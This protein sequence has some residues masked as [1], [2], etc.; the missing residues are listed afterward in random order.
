MS[1]PCIIPLPGALGFTHVLMYGHFCI[2]FLLD[3]LSSSE[4]N[5]FKFIHKVRAHKRQPEFDFE[6]YQFFHSGVISLD[7]PSKNHDYFSSKWRCVLWTLSSI[8]S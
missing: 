6:L 5:Y 4:A 8:F 2:W 1:A 7:L 3:S